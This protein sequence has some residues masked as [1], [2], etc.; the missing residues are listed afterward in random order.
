M[1]PTLLD[2]EDRLLESDDDKAELFNDFFVRQA[3][4][5]SVSGEPL[6][7]FLSRVK[8]EDKFLHEFRVS[9]EEV[10]AALHPLDLSKAPGCD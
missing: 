3:V 6:I 4:E 2:Q 10:R 1:T 7:I 5:S 9:P 8:T